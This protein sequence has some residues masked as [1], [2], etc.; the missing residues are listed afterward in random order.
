[1]SNPN[2]SG[3]ETPGGQESVASEYAPLTGENAFTGENAL[4]ISQEES[5]GE[6]TPGGQESVEG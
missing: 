1:M 5:S 4:S 3:E 6:D 2:L